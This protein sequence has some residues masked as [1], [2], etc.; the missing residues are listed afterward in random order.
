MTDGP[1]RP[2]LDDYLHRLVVLDT[3]GPMLY[4]GQLDAA[5]E[6]GY[7]LSGAD[8]HD[9]AEGHATNEEYVNAAR[10]LEGS[11]ERHVNRHRVF[12]ERHAVISLSALDDVVT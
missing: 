8:V 10:L 5:D 6:R 4:I 7:W 11:G 1:A 12:V 3:A 9:R 2:S